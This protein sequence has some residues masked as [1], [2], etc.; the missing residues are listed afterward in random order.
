MPIVEG[1]SR[2]LSSFARGASSMTDR[3]P[4]LP[5]ACVLDT[6]TVLALWMFE[7]PALPALRAAADDGRLR[8]L[9]SEATL[10]ELRRV[11]AYPQFAQSAQR[12]SEILAAYRAACA[13]VAAG[14]DA[15]LP[16]CRDPDDQKFLDLAL[17]GAA[18]LLLSRDKALL[19]LAR[20]RL[21][22]SRLAILTPEAAQ[23]ML[24]DR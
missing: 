17:A 12:Q 3:L 4:P 6:N 5:A 15:S 22:R 9:A 1:A 18:P 23:R 8:P 24:Q 20:H 13:I 2:P 10:E 21:L 7:D 11:L 16:A 19:R 14:T